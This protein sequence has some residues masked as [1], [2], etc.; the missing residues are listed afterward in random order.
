MTLLLHM[1]GVDEAG[2]ADRLG[3]LLGDR[4][5]YRRDDHF[6]P[7]S[8][9]YILA[10][11]PGPDAF[12]GLS[13]L[14]AILS[15]GAGVDSLLD[16]RG[17]PDGVPII[18]FSDP[19]LT[20][21]MRDYV[22]AEVLA[23]HRLETR[24]RAQQRRREWTQIA[25]P[26]AEDINVGVMGLGVLGKAAL[27][28][29]A[30]FGYDLVGWS[31]SSNIVPGVRAFWGAEGLVP[32]LEKTDIL[33]CLLP[34]TRETRGILNAKTFS[35]LRRG[36]L[37]GGPVVINAARGALQ[38]EAD[39]AVA[40]RDGTLGAASV[41]VFET[42]PL[43]LDSPL[44]GLHNCRITPHVAAVSDPAAGAIYFAGVIRDFEAGWSMPHLVDRARGY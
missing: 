31:R 21:R 11:K 7:A 8:I 41:D 37:P 23:H 17:L 12:A 4:P 43:A 5:V 25:P 28:A 10:W 2:W 1:N 35:A 18:R 30:G 42:E 14:K 16:H 9:D 6:D 29:L 13:N 20:G 33:V 15:Y 22:V 32:F 24:F 36:W 3:P 38:V 26:R 44:W 19:D 39:L 40:L 27:A 34:L